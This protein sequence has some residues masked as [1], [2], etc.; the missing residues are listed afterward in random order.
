MK[1]LTLIYDASLENLVTPIFE[2]GMA[3]TRYSKIEGVTG[4]R[5]DTLAG[6]EYA[7][8]GQNTL[9]LVIADDGTMEGIV[10]ELRA[11]R[12][13]V[14]HGLRGVVTNAETVI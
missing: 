9:I 1:L 7:S 14:G 2:R 6:G 10:A 4:A 12:E 5:M 8:E 11:L 13:Q 3:V